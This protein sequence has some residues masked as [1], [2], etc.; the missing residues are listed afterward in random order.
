MRAIPCPKRSDDTS[1][2]STLSR[3]FFRPPPRHLFARVLFFFPSSKRSTPPIV[4]YA[5]HRH[6]IT[7]EVVEFTFSAHT[8]DPIFYRNTIRLQRATTTSRGYF[9]NFF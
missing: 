8:N 5:T 2:F 9:K 7:Y 4:T 3:I 1:A 6:V